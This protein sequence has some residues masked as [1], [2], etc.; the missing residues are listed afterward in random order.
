MIQRVFSTARPAT[1]TIATAL[2]HGTVR[3]RDAGID[4]P[5][6]DARLL[7]AQALGVTTEALLRD[8][9]TPIDPPTT[10]GC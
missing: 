9:H 3:L 5:R 1:P 4:S 8:P 2:R 6:L 7:L 10:S